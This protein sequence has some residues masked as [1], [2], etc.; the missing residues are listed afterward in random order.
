MTDLNAALLL[1]LVADPEHANGD[2]LELTRVAVAGGVSMVQLRAKH[3]TDRELLRLAQAMRAVC[4]NVPFIVN[5][6]IDIAIA[7]R[8]DGV[9]LGVDDLPLEAARRLGGERFII[10]YSPDTE[11]DL[12]SARQRGASYLGIG[13]VFGTSTKSDAGNALGLE[14]FA[15]RVRVGD[16]PSVGIGGVTVENAREVID[17]GA[18]GVAVV[19]AILRAADPYR[20]AVQLSTNSK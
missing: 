14:E 18:Q 4:H 2:V 5:D 3:V 15:R 10:G 16:L 8:A 7:A 13:P 9:H 12:I 1:Y 20:A 6:R 11:S 19:S 17:A